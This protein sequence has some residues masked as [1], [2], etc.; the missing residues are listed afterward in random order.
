ME[1]PCD[2]RHGNTAAEPMNRGWLKNG[3]RPGDFAKAPRCGAKNRRGLPCQCPAMRN[4]R[5]RLH[6]GLSTGPRT[7]EGRE[8][9]RQAAVTHGF[10]TAKAVA[11]RKAAR[12]AYRAARKWMRELRTA[13]CDPRRADNR[14]ERTASPWLGS[15]AAASRAAWE[16]S[17]GVGESRCAITARLGSAGCGPSGHPLHH[18]PGC[19]HARAHPRGARS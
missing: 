4:G 7:L 17:R 13:R 15:R 3:N 18:A 14:R 6:G 16:P 2:S 11:Q 5:C 12:L 8:R 19:G 10:Y 9:A 1:H